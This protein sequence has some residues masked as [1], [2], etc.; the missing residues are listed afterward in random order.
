MGDDA[1]IAD[2]V[3]LHSG[4]RQKKRAAIQYSWLLMSS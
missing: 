3:E 1:E 2:V 4:V